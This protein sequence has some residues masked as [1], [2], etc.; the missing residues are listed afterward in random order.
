MPLN[1]IGG[2]KDVREVSQELKVFLPRFTLV[3]FASINLSFALCYHGSRRYEATLR[4]TDAGRGSYRKF[5]SS[6]S[7]CSSLTH[8]TEFKASIFL[9]LPTHSRADLFNDRPLFLTLLPIATRSTWPKVTV[10]VIRVP[11]GTL[12]LRCCPPELPP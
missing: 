7:F 9:P 3:K 11:Y 5:W 1:G 12:H 2:V 4:G 8:P 10:S 6:C